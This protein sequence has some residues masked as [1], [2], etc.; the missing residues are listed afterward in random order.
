MTSKLD[1]K[2]PLYLK[3]V[4]AADCILKSKQFIAPIDLFISL[5]LLSQKDV[6]D[7]RFKRIPY[8]EKAI[9]CN[10]GKALRILELLRY[11]SVELK[12]KPSITVYMNHGKG[13]KSLLRF[14]KTGN[15]IIEKAYSTHFVNIA[16]ERLS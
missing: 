14:S 9:K 2:D 4:D 5:S 6:A 10:L 13:T 7:W 12:L 16:S 8:L 1:N 15:K 11:Y 3:I